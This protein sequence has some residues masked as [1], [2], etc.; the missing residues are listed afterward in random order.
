M[1]LSKIIVWVPRY[2]NIFTKC[3]TPKTHKSQQGRHTASSILCFKIARGCKIIR[4]LVFVLSMPISLAFIRFYWFKILG[5]K[6]I[7]PEVHHFDFKHK[8]SSI[9]KNQ[10]NNFVELII[11]LILIFVICNFRKSSILQ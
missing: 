4:D 1:S 5:R 7:L 10:D 6:T 2:A 3:R 11:T 8:K 9:S